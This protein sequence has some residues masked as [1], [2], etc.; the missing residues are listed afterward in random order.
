MHLKRLTIH[1]I[2]SIED[3]VIDFEAHPLAD[4]EVFL[5]TGRT[6]AGKSTIL[7]AICLA[8]YADT[9]RLDNSLM[10]GTVEPASQ[11][12]V[13]LSDPRVM[14]RRNTGEGYV[15]LDFTGSDGVEYRAWWGVARA[16]KKPTGKLQGREWRLTRLDSGIVYSKVADIK[17]VM[18]DAIGLD[19]QQFCRTTMLAQGDFTRFLNSRDEDKSAILEK[20]TGTEIYTAIGKKVYELTRTHESAYLQYRRKTEAVTL[21]SD[22]ELRQLLDECDS[23]T[24]KA[25]AL[26]AS[27]SRLHSILTWRVK[28]NDISRHLDSAKTTLSIAQ[29]ALQAPELEANEKTLIDYQLSA[30]ALKLLVQKEDNI[31]ELERQKRGLEELAEYYSR[32]LGALAVHER[33]VA[34]EMQDVEKYNKLR[35]EITELEKKIE[36]LEVGK[37]RT[38][39]EATLKSL[40]EVVSALNKVNNLRNET[41]RREKL[42]IELNDALTRLKAETEK[43]LTLKGALTQATKN[44]DKTA[45]L[46]E[47]Q[48]VTME[49]AAVRMR[50]TLKVGDTCPVCLQTV[51]IEPPHEEALRNMF[52]ET[53]RHMNEARDEYDRLTRDLAVCQ[54]TLAQ[55][56]KATERLKYELDNDSAYRKLAT[57]TEKA[58]VLCGIGSYNESSLSQLTELEHNLKATE[59]A[60]RPLLEEAEELEKQLRTFKNRAEL[61]RNMVPQ[62]E[63]SNAMLTLERETLREVTVLMPEWEQINASG[64]LTP[65]RLVENTSTLI[66]KIRS[67]LELIDIQQGKIQQNDSN[68]FE[69]TEANPLITPTRLEYL[70]SLSTATLS[71]MRDSVRICYDNVSN[72]KA[73]LTTLERQLAE[74]MTDRPEDEAAEMSVEYLTAEIEKLDREINILGQQTGALQQRLNDDRAR[75]DSLV[76]QQKEIERLHNEW[77]RWHSLNELIGDAS[78]TKFRLIAQSY[79]LDTLIQHANVYMT[80]LTERYTLEVTPGTFIISIVDAWQGYTRRVASTLSGGESFLVSLALALALSDIGS[81]LAVDTLFIDE[82]FGSLSGE[83]LRMAIDTLRSLHNSSGR[84]VGII[85]HVEALRERIN[86]QMRVSQ[87]AGSSSS[88]IEIGSNF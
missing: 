25:T 17:A 49:Q 24:A 82:G 23:L 75:R 58:C 57:E 39:R 18:T 46:Y 63:A 85:S 86:V 38:R 5:I 54:T 28:V 71:R 14:L 45:D 76:G 44:R 31:K 87:P 69:W 59:E 20:I 3:A 60:D 16:R 79:V 77:L 81:R 32:L 41:T 2:A 33:R 64:S 72:A 47:C 37:I 6:G 51:V 35:D 7:D 22:A 11:G 88:I 42:L 70:K 55:L 78:G 10:Q 34:R 21:L 56:Q 65:T 48:R 43:E 84:K 73:Q 61:L 4:A 36:A 40:N 30:D 8:L 74:A 66:G 12:D 68:L 27:R 26:D 80:A 29:Q 62:A 19:F 9:P 67:T 50:N 53:V 83:A 15:E 1:N 13:K 52:R